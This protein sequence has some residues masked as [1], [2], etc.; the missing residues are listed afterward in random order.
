MV[1]LR[2]SAKKHEVDCFVLCPG[3]GPTGHV[4]LGDGVRGVG[5]EALATDVLGLRARK[6]SRARQV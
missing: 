1:R 2:A 3:A 6:S 4:G 5:I